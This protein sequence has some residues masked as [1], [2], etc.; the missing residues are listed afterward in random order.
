MW[1]TWQDLWLTRTFTK[2]TK[3]LVFSGYTINS[4]KDIAVITDVTNGIVIYNFADA[5]TWVFTVAT[6]TLVLTYNTNTASFADTDELV[7]NLFWAVATDPGLDIAKTVDQS[8]VRTRRTDAEAI[9]AAAQ[10]LTTSFADLWPEI[11]CR[12][13]N[14]VTIWLKGTVN[15][16]TGI[17]LRALGKHTY[18]GTEE[19]AL[20]IE[21]VTTAVINVTPE[22]VQFPDWIN[23]LYA[24]TAKVNNSIPYIQ[25]QVKMSVDGG[26][27][28]TIDT[29]NLTKGY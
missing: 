2:S 11:D 20:P 1:Y 14:T 9:I 13:F 17:Q 26:T 7:V 29:A 28:W 15:A 8:P 6:Q 4:L 18:A 27:D 5:S 3:T 12:G 22:I 10:T 21:S 24:I 23:F 25:R 16:S 19:M